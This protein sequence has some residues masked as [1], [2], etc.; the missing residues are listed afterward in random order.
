M[1][2][3]MKNFAFVVFF[4]IIIN[5]YLFCE[6]NEIDFLLG[7]WYGSSSQFMKYFDTNNTFTLSKENELYKLEYNIQFAKGTVYGNISKD[8]NR[9]KLG[10]NEYILNT[11][12]NKTFSFCIFL[13]KLDFPN[14]RENAP[15]CYLESKL[16]HDSWPLTKKVDMMRGYIPLKNLPKKLEQRPLVGYIN[17]DGVRLRESYGLSGKIIKILDKNILVSI[18]E[19]SPTIEIING[20]YEYWYKIINRKGETGWV[21]GAYLELSGDTMLNYDEWVIN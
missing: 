2:S 6:E 19:I 21:Y 11:I 12:D 17:D 8:K 14:L 15:I 7:Q 20:R 1:E 4:A 9:E 5:C 10:W 16:F 18:I 13:N 3:T